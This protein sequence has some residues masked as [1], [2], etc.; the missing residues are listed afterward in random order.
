MPPLCLP[1]RAHRNPLPSAVDGQT[2]HRVSRITFAQASL[3]PVD[4]GQ[5]GELWSNDISQKFAEMLIDLEESPYIRVLVCQEIEAQE[6]R[7]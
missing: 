6:R 7:R 5:I 3:D 4:R 1:R 2:D